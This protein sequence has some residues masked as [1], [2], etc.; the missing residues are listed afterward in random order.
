MAAFTRRFSKEIEMEE[1]VEKIRERIAAVDPSGP[2]KVVG[3]IQVDIQSDE[4]IKHLTIDL[5]NLDVQES[6]AD[7]ADITL[8]TDEETFVSVAQREISLNDA[9]ESGKAK[10]SGD[11]DLATALEEVWKNR[12]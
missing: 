9:L 6:A 4:G 12:E 11:T 1:V 8:E 10:L 7:S 5:K 3:V 2:R